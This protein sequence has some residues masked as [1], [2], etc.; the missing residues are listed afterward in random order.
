MNI[1]K[2]KAKLIK[3]GFR[4]TNVTKEYN[5]TVMTAKRQIGRYREEK[6]FT[7]DEKGEETK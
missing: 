7:F 1:I 3:E 4:I 2:R 5:I 6:I